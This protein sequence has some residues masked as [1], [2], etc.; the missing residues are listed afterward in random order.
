MTRATKPS[1]PE[2]WRRIRTAQLPGEGTIPFHQRLAQFCGI[3]DK[4]AKTLELE[5]R[6][7]LYLSARVSQRIEPDALVRMAWT[8]HARHP[9][10]TAF[11]RDT[12]GIDLPH[13]PMPQGAAFGEA[14]LRARDQYAA[15]F[16]A[17]PPASF[18]GGCGA[19]LPG[20]LDLG[21]TAALF[22]LGSLIIS[23]AGS[24][25]PY[26]G[27]AIVLGAAVHAVLVGARALRRQRA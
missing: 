27:G 17:P 25:W 20:K 15:E 24:P 11:C 23:L 14:R 9:E 19:R 22:V 6:R 16:G 5:Y 7:F 13:R 26:L 2:H 3:P 21:V 4:K 12:L 18:W 8:L 1:A 10:Y